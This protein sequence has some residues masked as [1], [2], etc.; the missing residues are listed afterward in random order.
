MCVKNNVSN[1]KINSANF[2]KK[3][4][5]KRISAEYLEV[6][7]QGQ[8]ISKSSLKKLEKEKRFSV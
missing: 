6:K 2:C 7:K 4:Y 8:T 5:I 3:K 1:I